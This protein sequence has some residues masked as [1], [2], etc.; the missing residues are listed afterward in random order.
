MQTSPGTGETVSIAPSVMD[1]WAA[2]QFRKGDQKLDHIGHISAL[3]IAQNPGGVKL[4]LFPQPNG[5]RFCR[6][7]LRSHPEFGLEPV[8]M[9]FVCSLMVREILKRV[10]AAAMMRDTPDRMILRSCSK[11]CVWLS[12]CEEAKA[13]LT[14]KDPLRY[15][16]ISKETSKTLPLIEN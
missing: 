3:T 15:M 2:V 7:S 10:P 4:P 8:G 14:P 12:S 5:L 1:I 6:P 16:W 13:L 9:Y 11:I